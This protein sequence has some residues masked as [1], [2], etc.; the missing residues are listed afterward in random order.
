MV[1]VDEIIT[2]Q[3]VKLVQGEGMP[4]P[5]NGQENL[6][7]HLKNVNELPKGDLYIRFDIQFPKKISNHHKQTILQALRQNEEEN[8]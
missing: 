5:I 1:T 8:E 3:T 4:V 2:P 6:L 7:D